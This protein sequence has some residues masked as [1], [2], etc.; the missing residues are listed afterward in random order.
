VPTPERRRPALG[1]SKCE[2]ATRG[3]WSEFASVDARNH[4]RLA[5]RNVVSIQIYSIEVAVI[6][7][8]IDTDRI[9]LVVLA[10][11]CKYVCSVF[12]ERPAS[13]PVVAVFAGLPIT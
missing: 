13:K 10:F 1:K 12:G 4:P 8:H 9:E 2:V 6:G 7:I 3:S 5:E 11:G